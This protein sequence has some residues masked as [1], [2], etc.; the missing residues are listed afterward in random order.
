MIQVAP[1]I[2]SA[3][4][5]RLGEDCDAIR[6]A[7]AD[8]LHF[9]VMDGMFVPNISFGIP[10]LKDLNNHTDMPIDVHLMIEE[11]HRYIEQFA[12]SG[13]DYIT[14]HVEAESDIE[15]TLKK[16]AD[17]GVIP[18]ISVKPGT[19]AQAVFPYLEQVGMI[20]VMSV[21]PGFGGQSFMPVAIDKVRALRE[22][23]NRRGL[24]EMLIEVDGG[25]N[26]ETGK[27][28]VDAGA[29]VLVAGSALFNAENPAQI[30]E[31]F[32]KMA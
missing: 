17:F 27:L 16:I 11:P 29:D 5:A 1:S 10:V 15:G 31:E 9:D 24:T 6:A 30:I 21:E 20:L 13:A 23:C 14:I 4:F 28:V 8:I 7:G 12:K 25:I 22:E 2:L 3:N 18:A 26:L 19:P 32:K